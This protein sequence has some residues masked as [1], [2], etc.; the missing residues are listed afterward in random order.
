MLSEKNWDQSSR[1]ESINFK[2]WLCVTSLPGMLSITSLV[3]FWTTL[4]CTL[5]SL[6]AQFKYVVAC[7]Q[8]PSW[9]LGEIAECSWTSRERSGKESRRSDFHSLRW[10]NF[11][12]TSLGASSRAKYD[13]ELEAPCV[14]YNKSPCREGGPRVLKDKTQLP[15]AYIACPLS[16][17]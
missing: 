9:V 15:S 2:Q 17:M 8:A 14:E 7:E 13:T 5:P 6:P 16:K 11:F 4:P 12:P 1:N 10:P 3:G